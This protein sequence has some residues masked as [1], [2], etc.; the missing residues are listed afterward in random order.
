MSTGLQLLVDPACD[1]LLS[2]S[3]AR[4]QLRSTFTNLGCPLFHGGVVRA[5]FMTVG[6]VKGHGHTPVVQAEGSGAVWEATASDVFQPPL[7]L[8]FEIASARADIRQPA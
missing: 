4:Q 2:R 7:S 1:L 3:L 8:T 5:V 6:V